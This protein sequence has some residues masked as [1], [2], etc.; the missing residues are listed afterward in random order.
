MGK[1]EQVEGGEKVSRTKPEGEESVAMSWPEIDTAL[2]LRQANKSGQQGAVCGS[3]T[4]KWPHN[5]VENWV[6]N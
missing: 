2:K 1:V 6:K 5:C 4:K 3:G